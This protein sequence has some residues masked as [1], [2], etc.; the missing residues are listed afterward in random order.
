MAENNKKRPKKDEKEVN[1]DAK[2]RKKIIEEEKN[3]LKKEAEKLALQIQAKAQ[4]ETQAQLSP[5]Q[6]DAAL[7]I[8]SGYTQKE[9]SDRLMVNLSTIEEWLKLPHFARAL[10]EYTIKE[11]VS[12]K[13]DRIR[14]QKRVV[15]EMYNA[16][17]KKIANSDLDGLSLSTLNDMLLKHSDRLDKLVDKKEEDVGKRDLTVLILN[18]AKETSGKQYKNF[19]EFLEDDDFRFPTIDVQ[20]EEVN[21]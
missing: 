2:T 13:N 10:N 11:G 6:K 18:H 9:V 1:I 21:E 7:L 3:K 12:D 20:A 14:K 19:E 17:M 15:E 16:L 5:E 4:L 8:A